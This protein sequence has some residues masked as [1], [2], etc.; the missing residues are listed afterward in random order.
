MSRE[1][2]IA[3][4]RTRRFALA[5]LAAAC[6][7]SLTLPADARAPDGVTPGKSCKTTYIASHS[8][9]ASKIDRARQKAR[10]NWE[11]QAWKKFGGKYN[12]WGKAQYTQYGCS[13]KGKHHF[14]V[15]EAFPCSQVEEVTG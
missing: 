14:C 9:K 10:G 7:A 8:Q 12:D 6:L 13:K 4:S 2:A 15:A 1:S 5:S 11:F 3:A